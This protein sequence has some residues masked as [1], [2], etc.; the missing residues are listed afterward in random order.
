MGRGREAGCRGGRTRA[1]GARGRRSGP[2]GG[3]GARRRAGGGGGRLGARAWE[4]EPR[5]KGF[6]GPPAGGSRRG[7]APGGEVLRA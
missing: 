4:A 6:T 5:P 2:S 1:R 3:D 7:R